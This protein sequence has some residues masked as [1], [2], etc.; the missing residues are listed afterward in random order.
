MQLVVFP[1]DTKKCIS[2]EVA[3]AMKKYISVLLAVFVFVLGMMTR[4]GF[5]A[6]AAQHKFTDV[7]GTVTVMDLTGLDLH[8][9]AKYNKDIQ[10]IKNELI[11]KTQFNK[12]ILANTKPL[13]IFAKAK[14][15]TTIL[16][17][18]VETSFK[19]T[20]QQYP[21]Y[22]ISRHYFTIAGSSISPI[23]RDDGDHYFHIIDLAN[24]GRRATSFKVSIPKDADMICVQVRDQRWYF[25]NSSE[26]V[27]RYRSF[28]NYVRPEYYIF[29]SDEAFKKA[30]KIWTGKTITGPIGSSSA[31]KKESVK[32]TTNQNKNNSKSKTTVQPKQSED[33]SD[34]LGTIGMVGVGIATV[35][36]IG[37]GVS[38]FLGGGEGGGSGAGT[39]ESVPQEPET[40]VYKDPATGAETLYELDPNTGEWFDPSTGAIT[41]PSKLEDYS[42]Q[43]MQDRAWMNGQMENMR[44][45][46]TDVDRAW[47]KQDQESAKEMQKKF[48]EIDRQGAKDKAAIRSGTYGMSDAQ[49][50]EYL[51]KRQEDYVSKQAAAHRTAENWDRAVTVAEGTG[52]L[53]DIGMDIAATYGKVVD[54]GLVTGRI[55]DG[56]TLLKNIAGSGADAYS[57]G[58]SVLGGMGK[59]F[60]DGLVD[61]AQ[62]NANTK[63]QKVAAFVGGDAFKAGLESGLKGE[64]A[65]TV[66]KKSFKGGLKGGAKL[67]IQEIG[68]NLE[69]KIQTSKTDSLKNAYD[70]A[71][72]IRKDFSKTISPK[73]VET[74]KQMNLEK[75]LTT[76][77]NA[78]YQ[79]WTNNIGN[80]VTKN[81]VPDAL[82]GE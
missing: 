35:G 41:D 48:E 1:F 38:R 73:S 33:D 71:R 64:S 69:N 80:A 51:N 58:N 5:A 66:L 36:A 16:V 18:A 15:G 53:A 56:Y 22:Y 63:I 14:P 28:K 9:Y 65:A 75:H 40:F 82:F 45:R 81:T 26:E 12:H 2:P 49:R 7:D 20:K 46:K 29:T 21:Q 39:A 4:N 3:C 59:G 57:K 47:Q 8:Y 78:N 17:K 13:R 72:E 50:T 44:D 55:A 42:R 19:V 6:G 52:K 34:G 25:S 11:P 54:G 77:K 74:L 70:H 23:T 37:F 30:Y 43:R 10:A 76:V 31:T 32:T 24:S 62:N 27:K 60:V 68:N 67:T 61:V 79:Y